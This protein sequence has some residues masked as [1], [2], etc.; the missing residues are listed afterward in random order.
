MSIVDVN[1][2]EESTEIKNRMKELREKLGLTQEKFADGLGYTPGLIGQ[3]ER[4]KRTL[5]LEVAMKVCD[6]FSCSL[7]WL[8][9]RK[10]DRDDTAG[11]IL[12]ALRKYFNIGVSRELANT[13]SLTVEVEDRLMEFLLNLFKFDK[14]ADESGL[15]ED[16]RERTVNEYKQKFND[17]I[18]NDD[19]KQ[20]K[21]VY[22]LVEEEMVMRVGKYLNIFTPITDPTAG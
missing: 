7:D 5:T 20:V 21:T 13:E 22:T 1:G 18:R 2:G 6:T 12:Q 17:A 3:I 11:N 16:V 8:Y 19:G 14:L 15:S 9:M 10:E 4:S